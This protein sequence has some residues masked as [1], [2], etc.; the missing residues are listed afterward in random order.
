MSD[1]STD[2]L[3]FTEDEIDELI[4]ERLI[5]TGTVHLVGTPRVKAMRERIK[6]MAFNELVDK[7]VSALEKE[8]AKP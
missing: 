6:R 1:T 4:N 3:R 2:P 5:A 8:A 7:G